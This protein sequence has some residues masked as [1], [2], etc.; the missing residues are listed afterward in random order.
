IPVPQAEDLAD[1]TCSNDEYTIAPRNP[2]TGQTL[3]EAVTEELVKPS[4]EEKQPKQHSQRMQYRATPIKG[5]IT[6]AHQT[7]PN[8]NLG[9]N[10]RDIHQQF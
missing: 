6:T 5:K 4:V 7:V 10:D 3:K 9:L 2:Y 1:D 8:W